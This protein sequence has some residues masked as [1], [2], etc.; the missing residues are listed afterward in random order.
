ML[1]CPLIC[2]V[3]LS[4]PLLPSKLIDGFIA[5]S[6]FFSTGFEEL[7]PPTP[8]ALNVLLCRKF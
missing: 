1:F 6:G 3:Y 4:N 5:G 8:G 7:N 2:E